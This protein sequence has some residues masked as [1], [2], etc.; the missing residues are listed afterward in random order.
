[1]TRARS[2]VRPNA[3]RRRA[4]GC[5][6]PKH[7]P[8]ESCPASSSY[9]PMYATSSSM[10]RCLL[11]SDAAHMASDACRSVHSLR[12]LDARLGVGVGTWRLT[13]GQTGVGGG[14]RGPSVLGAATTTAPPRSPAHVCASS[15]PVARAC[16][17]RSSLPTA[18]AAPAT[19]ILVRHHGA[20]ALRGGAPAAR[21][22]RGARWLQ[23][24]RQGVLPPAAR[25]RHVRASLQAP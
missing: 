5:G 6:R 25:A 2:V 15:G 11:A 12:R 18:R 4:R 1:M 21:E 24:Q 14:G 13:R 19:A 7:Q 22:R 9:R 10:A 8:S 20:R 16:P 17:R 23:G 3:A